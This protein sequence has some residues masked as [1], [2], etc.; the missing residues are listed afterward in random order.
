MQSS[1][2]LRRVLR[3]AVLAIAVAPL[4]RA[5]D[6][7]PPVQLTSQADHANYILPHPEGGAVHDLF[8]ND[9][10]DHA[11]F[12]GRTTYISAHL[13]AAGLVS[14]LMSKPAN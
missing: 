4:A 11:S 12:Q 13:D 9:V 2:S 10:P 14:V 5:A 1:R 8:G 7:E 3:T 6:P